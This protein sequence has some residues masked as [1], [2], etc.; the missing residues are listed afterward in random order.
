MLNFGFFFNSICLKIL[1]LLSCKCRLQIYLKGCN[2]FEK[3]KNYGENLYSNKT[4]VKA[5][6]VETPF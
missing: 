2:P 5:L 4:M 6:V 1:I 3:A